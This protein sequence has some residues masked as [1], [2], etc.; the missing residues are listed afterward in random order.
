[1]RA[2]SFDAVFIDQALIA[3]DP[4]SWAEA[5]AGDDG[6]AALVLMTGADDVEQ[7][8]MWREEA[9]AILAPP[10]DLRALRAALRAVA[11]ECV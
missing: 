5:R 11:K 2:G 9:R 10:F 8:R 6:R 3:A 1:L 7:S 4:V